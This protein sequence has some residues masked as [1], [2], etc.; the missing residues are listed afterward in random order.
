SRGVSAMQPI[1]SRLIQLLAL[2]TIFSLGLAAC[3]KGESPAASTVVLPDDGVPFNLR[4]AM[5]VPP[6]YE[7]FTGDRFRVL[8]WN[9]EHFV[10][11]YDDPYIDNPE[12]DDPF[13]TSE[14][15]ILLFTDV[16]RAADADGV[17]LP[18]FE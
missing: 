10:D 11:E 16:L 1:C 13:M 3:G 17:P 4:Q 7:S 8:V 5:A 9:V 15:Q 6:D 2:A 14:E 18:G 12:E